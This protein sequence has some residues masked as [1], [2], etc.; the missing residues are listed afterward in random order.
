MQYLSLH[1]CAELDRCSLKLEDSSEVLAVTT[2]YP[3]SSGS[4]NSL[5]NELNTPS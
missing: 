5:M 2:H 1:R 3:E 4:H